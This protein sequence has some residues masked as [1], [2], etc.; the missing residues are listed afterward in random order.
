MLL[1]LSGKALSEPLFTVVVL[2]FILA[3]EQYVPEWRIAWFVVAVGLV[4]MAFLLRYAG[5]ALVVNR[6]RGAVPRQQ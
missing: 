6:S 1:T 3:L 5:L 4:W 2:L